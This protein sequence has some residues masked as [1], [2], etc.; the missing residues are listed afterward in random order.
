MDF[1]DIVVHMDN[2]QRCA[3]RLDLAIR[4]AGKHKARLTGLYVVTHP[5]YQP[6]GESMNRKV[7]EAEQMFRQRTDGVDIDTEYLC[8]DAGAAGDGMAEILN[9]YTHT[10]DL[11]VVGQTDPCAL[12]TGVPADLPE[13]VI[14][15]SGRAVLIVP[16]AGAFEDIGT[17]VIIG[18]KA[19]RASARAVNDAMPLLLHAEEV[20][21]LSIQPV[22]DRQTDVNRTDGDICSHLKRYDIN[23]KKEDLM[24]AD[25]PV[26][27]IMMS[28]AW[29]NGCDLIVVG[30][31]VHRS[32]GLL[33]LGPVDRAFLEKMTVPVLMSH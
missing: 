28:Y 33:H 30:A 4:L 14:E 24:T 16:F 29:E 22:D 2:T 17:R 1:K 19:G 8:V 12:E 27:D 3:V 15:G 23:I 9:Y 5:H 32:C 11:I 6:Q 21:V 26:A 25:I 7:Q 10:K 13:R 31:Y 20:C 18:W